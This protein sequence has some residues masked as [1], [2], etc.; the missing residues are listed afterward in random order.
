MPHSKP[1]STAHLDPAD[2]ALVMAKWGEFA[3]AEQQWELAK[4][5]AKE[6][7]AVAKKKLES[8]RAFMKDLGA[9]GIF[10]ESDRP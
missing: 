6:Y 7:K 8:F 9:P 5:S 1:P 3:D 4:E 2:A 10:D